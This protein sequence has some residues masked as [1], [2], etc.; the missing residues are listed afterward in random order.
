MK[1]VVLLLSWQGHA[2]PW[3]LVCCCLRQ[4]FALRV[5][6]LPLQQLPHAAA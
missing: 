2:V 1:G 5:P 6:L 3:L 4:R